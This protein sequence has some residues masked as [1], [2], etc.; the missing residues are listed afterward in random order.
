MAEPLASHGIQHAF[1]VIKHK[2]TGRDT[3]PYDIH[4]ILIFF[5]D[6]HPGYELD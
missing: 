1:D 2:V 6:I 5:Q 3:H 4:Q